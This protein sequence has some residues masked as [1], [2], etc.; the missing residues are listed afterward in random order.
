MLSQ[1][2]TNSEISSHAS[3]CGHYAAVKALLSVPDLDINTSDLDMV[4]PLHKAIANN[5]LDVV[6]LLLKQ[7]SIKVKVKLSL[8]RK[9]K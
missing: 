2:S 7:P 1:L 3:C 6:E 4:S 5:H 9:F 8:I